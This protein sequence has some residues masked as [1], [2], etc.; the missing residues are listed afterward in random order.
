MRKLNRAQAIELF[1]NYFEKIT[2]ENKIYKSLNEI[3]ELQKEKLVVLDVGANIGQT[4][5]KLVI[6]IIKFSK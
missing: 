5:G 6:C 3:V 2:F 1:I 4:L